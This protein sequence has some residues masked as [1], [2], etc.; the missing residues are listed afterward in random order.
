LEKVKTA[1]FKQIKLN[2]YKKL[3]T[4]YVVNDC[5]IP[6]KSPVTL[7]EIIVPVRNNGCLNAECIFDIE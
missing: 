1:D 6:L 7:S 3:G 2:I 5:T 4:S